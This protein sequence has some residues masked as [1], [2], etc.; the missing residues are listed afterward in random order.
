MNIQS[1]LSSAIMLGLI[2]TLTA[3]NSSNKTTSTN[4]AI[5]AA[6]PTEPEFNVSRFSSNSAIV[7]NSYFPLKP[8]TSY[9]FKGKGEK[10]GERIEVSVSHETRDIL[11]VKSVIVV[12]RNFEDGELVEET[13]DWYAQDTDGNV[14][15]MGEDSRE[16]EEGEIVSFAGSWEAGKDIDGVG[17]LAVAGIQMKKS[18]YVVGDTYLQEF[19]ETVAEDMAEITEDN[20]VVGG[21]S[22]ELADGSLTTGFNTLRTKE[23]SPL[24]T[25]PASTEEYKY[26][27]P[28]VGLVLETDIE[29]GER[30]ELKEVLDDTQPKITAEDFTNPTVIDNKYFPLV[31]GTRTTYK[32]TEG[33]DEELIILDVL[34]D[35]RQVMGVTTVVVRDRVYIDGDENTGILIED[36]HDWYAQDDAGNVWY[37]GETVDNFDEDTGEFV[38]NGGSWEAG[39]GGAQPGIQMKASPR[40]GDSYHQEFWA[41]EAEDLAAIVGVDVALTLENGASFNTLKFKEWN[42]LEA[43]STE[44][45]YYAPGVGFV[46]E[47]KFDDSGEIEEVIELL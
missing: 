23:W 35:T 29:G 14:W 19:Y 28:G 13:F 47:E 34:S 27:A 7:D 3:C 46:R 42:P 16:I 43:D 9:L 15:Y 4:T 18:P 2:T 41:G 20:A 8:G 36:T 25:D 10:S 31:P 30:I 12:D 1:K 26:F 32:T 33:E 6:D 22:V 40:F 37:M 24:A 11:G 17:K 39:V 38:D 5:D 21:L 44:F 45:K